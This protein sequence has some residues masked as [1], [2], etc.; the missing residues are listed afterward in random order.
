ME[1]PIPVNLNNPAL[2][3]LLNKSKSV[4][5]KID[6]SNPIVLSEATLKQTAAEAMESPETSEPLVPRAAAGYTREQVM[7]S[8]MPEA[9]KQAML[10]SI[11]VVETTTYSLNDLEDDNIQ[12]IHNKRKP[13][14]KQVVNETRLTNSNS[15][16]ITLS[17]AELKEMIS[18]SLVKFL[19]ESY[20]KTLEC[21]S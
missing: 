20:N 21:I 8:K 18:E 7:A 14:T 5:K 3:A 10:K 1:N 17:R 13:I 16:M 15:D 12:M 11:P 19:T 6:A 2:M 4:M 9:V